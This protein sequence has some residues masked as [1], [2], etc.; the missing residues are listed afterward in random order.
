MKGYLDRIED[1]GKAVVILEE[2]GFEILLPIRNLPEGSRV[3]SW[4]WIHEED[5]DFSFVLDEEERQRREQQANRMTQN[6]RAKSR[7][8][9]YK[10]E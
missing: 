2:E 9:Q 6:I 10:R 7:G 3:N 5:G 8:S 1:G 4:F